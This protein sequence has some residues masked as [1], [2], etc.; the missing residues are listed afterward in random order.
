MGVGV[1]GSSRD[2]GSVSTGRTVQGDGRRRDR[3][4]IPGISA[5]VRSDGGI[6]GA[7]LGGGV[8]VD[9]RRGGPGR[10]SSSFLSNHYPQQKRLNYHQPSEALLER[11]GTT[12]HQYVVL[13]DTL[14]RVRDTDPFPAVA[15]A[16]SAVIGVVLEQVDVL[17]S[18]SAQVGGGAG[19][20]KGDGVLAVA[21][22]V[23]SPPR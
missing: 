9:G 16:A 3:T 19:A 4:H 11:I 8:G 7:G 2:V 22:P 21:T 1:R 14:E 23:V 13:W 15:E 12:A 17:A 6:D 18:A 20:G 5:G 10:A